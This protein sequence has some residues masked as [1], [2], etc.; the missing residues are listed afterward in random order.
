MEARTGGP[1]VSGTVHSEGMAKSSPRKVAP[2]RRPELSL[3]DLRPYEAGELRPDGDH[4]GMA[5]TELELAG[6]DGGGSTFLECGIYRCGLDRTRLARARLLD[7]ELTG[8]W[9]V[10]TE[11]AGA[12]IRDVR[13]SDARLGGT[14]LHGARLTRTVISGGK[15]DFLNLRQAVLT[16]VAF[17]S[18]VLVEPDFGGA[19]L[20][21]VTF[22]G[23]ALRQADF[24]GVTMRDVDLRAAAEVDIATGMDR[25]SG[26]VISTSQLMDLAPAFAAQLGVRVED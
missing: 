7:S 4:D 6:M 9:G 19:R 14:Q 1:V 25:L 22:E 18:C 13:L 2:V 8:V 20:E 21:R 5:F 16:D 3:P 17:E 24:H 11:L 10:G 26:A 12:E 15:I 23:C